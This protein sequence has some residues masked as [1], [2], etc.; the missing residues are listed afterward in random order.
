MVLGMGIFITACAAY[1]VG[2][3]EPVPGRGAATAE[4]AG[5]QSCFFL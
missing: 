5:E 2:G 1:A 4:V 3:P